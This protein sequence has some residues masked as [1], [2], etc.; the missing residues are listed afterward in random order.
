MYIHLIIILIIYRDN[1]S[2]CNLSQI[3]R[4]EK[5]RERRRN[6][7]IY[8]QFLFFFPKIK[9]LSASYDLRMMFPSFFKILSYC[10]IADLQ[11]LG[12]FN[13]SLQTCQDIVS[14][15]ILHMWQIRFEMSKRIVFFFF[16]K[17]YK[18]IQRQSFKKTKE[19]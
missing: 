19:N 1:V 9:N 11:F 5:E 12:I 13:F 2:E 14:M 3:L 7:T 17:Y 4:I 16:K 6:F 18:W 8:N 15:W 10:L